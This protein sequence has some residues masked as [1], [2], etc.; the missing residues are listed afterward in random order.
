[1][2]HMFIFY[3]A[4]LSA[5][6]PPVAITLYAA[7]SLS[8]AGIWDSGIAAMKLAAT[9]YIIPF[10]FVYGPAI[11]L[12]GSWDRVAMAVVSAC[13]GIVCLASS[14]HGYLLRNS[15][16]WERIL[17]FAAALVLIKPGVGTD[18]IGLALF[19]LVLL[20]Q[21]LGRGVPETAREVA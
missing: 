17:L 19:V 4:I 3:F 12:I 7:N 14:L 8:G 10:M 11:L 20:S 1:A 5:I 2:A 18:A 16:F 6:T 15:Y 9:G 13:L 21:R